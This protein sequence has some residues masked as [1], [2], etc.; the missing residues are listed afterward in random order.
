M[1]IKEN[2][3][4]NL[5][6]TEISPSIPLRPYIK[7]YYLYKG[8]AG[9]FQNSFFRAL[10]NGSVEMFFLFGGAR[11]IFR[12][13]RHSQRLPAFLAG[14]FDLSYPMKIRVETTTGELKGISVL[15]THAGVN[16]LLRTK[17]KDLTN[18]VTG[19]DRSGYPDLYQQYMNVYEQEEGEWFRHLNEFFLSRLRNNNQPTQKIIPMLNK[20]ESMKGVLS[21]ER[22]AS[23]LRIS[24]KILYRKFIDELGISPKTYLKII[25]FNRAC[26]LLN[27]TSK[28]NVTEIVLKCGY[29]DQPHFVRE[30]KSIMKESPRHYVNKKRGKFYVSRPYALR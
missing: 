24:Y 4:R 27:Q 30:F 20:L 12:E 7:G 14:I 8:R 29:Y 13:R 5:E 18:R 11:I 25:R 22:L 3:L 23:E 10:P 6:V 9:G 26:Y 15:F 2:L 21:V 28:P 19:I 16:Q 17:L 1:S